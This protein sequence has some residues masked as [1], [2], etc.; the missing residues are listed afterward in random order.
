MQS[1]TFIV[2]L[3]IGPTNGVAAGYVSSG[4]FGA[5]LA[6][7]DTGIYSFPSQVGI[8]TAGLATRGLNVQ[9]TLTGAAPLI[10][11]FSAAVNVA[12]ANNQIIY[13]FRATPTFTPGAFTGLSYRGIY[14]SPV[15]TAT[16]T[17]PGDSAQIDVDVLTGTGATNAFGIRIAPPTGASNNYL[18]AHTTAA[19][20]NI[21]G[22]GAQTMAG[23]L[24]A[25]GNVTGLNIISTN[26]LTVGGASY[27]GF[28]NRSTMRSPADG[29]Y[30]FNNNAENAG[31]GLDFATDA[32]LKIRTR[33]QSA[34][35]ALE[36]LSVL[37]G[38]SGFGG[39]AVSATT[40]LNC[41]AAASGFSS[42]RMAHGSAPS[43]PVN[44][45][46]WTTTAGLFVRINGATVGP[47]S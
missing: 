10:G 12:A 11:V 31:V 30:N 39:A 25:G 38:S 29:Q 24:V 22:A 26:S 7:P 47:L 43:S 17:N 42:L 2:P 28:L 45:D 13:G 21:T 8:G 14:L 4:M 9:P 37:A 27:I 44:G 1:D 36:C 34:N 6:V 3:G 16:W 32:T 5:L 40:G 41:V 33:A 35:A 18:I 19:T 20:F 46:M 23:A 15:S